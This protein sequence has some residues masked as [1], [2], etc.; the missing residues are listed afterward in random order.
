[1]REWA[2]QNNVELA[3]TPHYASWL[4]RIEAQFRA[5][6][7]FTLAGTDHPDHATQAPP[8][9]PIH[10]LAQP[11][12]QQ[13]QAK[14]TVKRHRKMSVD[15]HRKMSRSIDLHRPVL[16]DQ[17]LRRAPVASV[18]CA[19]G[20]LQVRLIA[21]MVGELDLHRTLNEPLRQLRQ[22]P[23]RPDDLILAAGAGEQLVDHLIRE[24][25]SNLSGKIAHSGRSINLTPAG[26]SLRSPSGLAPR[27]AS[28]TRILRLHLR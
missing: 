26:I 11:Q 17:C 23:A 21:Q 9:P 25:L 5:L 20:R 18:A 10:P 6:R 2:A 27:N 12:H 3:Y 16:G 15:Q 22:K 24:K 1:M 8:H 19:T 4:N 28:G 14:T 13:P 7:Y